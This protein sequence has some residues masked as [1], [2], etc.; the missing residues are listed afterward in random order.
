[1]KKTK[2]AVLGPVYPYKGGISHYTGL[3]IRAL[4]KK[5]EV[6]C[7]SYSLQYP[8]LLFKKEQ[9]DYANRA[10]EIEDSRFAVN[11]AN[12]LSWARAAAAIRKEE[13]ALLIVQWWHPYFAPCYQGLLRH[14]KTIPVFFTCHNVLPHERFP[15][16]RFLTKN[17]LKYAAGCIVHSSEDEENLKKLLPAMPHRK[18]PHPSYN[19]FRLKGMSRGEA[20]KQLGIGEEEKLLLFFGLVRKY[21]G[22]DHLIAAAPRL[23][24]ADPAIRIAVVGDFGDKKDEY[25]KQIRESGAEERFLIRDGYVPDAEVEPY[26]AAADLCVCPYL[27]ATQSGIVQI[28]FGFG[29]PVI[30]TNVGGLPEAVTDGKTGFIVPP[31][32][33]DALAAAILRFFE[34]DLAEEFRQN[35]DAEAE[36]FSWDRMVETI[37][38][39]YESSCDHSGL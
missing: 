25:A 2:I 19:A 12:P 18:N 29:L 22:L 7:F 36:R 14:L 1:M 27:S 31:A 24:A 35:V 10:F 4:R 32:D 8:K 34:E 26:F 17:T 16:D 20:R 38:E 13:P 3:L 33:P 6:L 9:R 23:V 15:L 30:A 11:T 37:G 39:L 5:Y 21:K 28:A